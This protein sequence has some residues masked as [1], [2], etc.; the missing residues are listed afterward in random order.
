MRLRFTQQPRM[1]A[2]HC[3]SWLFLSKQGI[4]SLHIARSCL[5]DISPHPL[6]VI[7]VRFVHRLGIDKAS[8]RDPGC[9]DIH[10]STDMMING[11]TKRVDQLLWLGCWWYICTVVLVASYSDYDGLIV[12][13]SD[14]L[15]ASH[16]FR[17]HHYRWGY[18]TA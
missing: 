6:A 5:W 14:S 8:P 7:S 12:Y 1:Y 15:N 18:S 9:R 16:S 11:C 3:L 13:L 2:P 10:G 17:T 4:V